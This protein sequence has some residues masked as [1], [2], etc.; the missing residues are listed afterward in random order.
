MP[1]PPSS[2]RDCR[3]QAGGEGR[4]YLYRNNNIRLKENLT[5]RPTGPAAFA[6]VRLS[7]TEEKA[8]N[9]GRRSP[10]PLRRKRGEAQ[11]QRHSRTRAREASSSS[12]FLALLAAARRCLLPPAAPPQVPYRCPSLS[13]LAPPRSSSRALAPVC[14]VPLLWAVVVVAIVAVCCA[15]FPLRR[16]YLGG[17]RGPSLVRAREVSVRGAKV[18][19]GCEPFCGACR[20]VCVCAVL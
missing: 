7:P 12:F 11:Q 10:P 9:S 3:P 6:V 16:C 20:V 2:A 18:P 19:P 5:E 13:P 8:P 4:A 17:I 1:L 15:L 14:R